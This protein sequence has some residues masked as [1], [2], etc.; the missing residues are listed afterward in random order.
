M[1]TLFVTVEEF[2]QNGGE[3]EPD[4]PLFTMSKS[5]QPTRLGWYHGASK[6]G[7]C[8]EAADNS[9]VFPM[10]NSIVFVEVQATPIYA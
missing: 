8:I 6:F 1:K 9:K 2:L 3:L 5:N 7:G 10:M 4:R